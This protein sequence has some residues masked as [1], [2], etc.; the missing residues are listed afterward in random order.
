MKITK[1]ISVFEKLL[2]AYKIA[3]KKNVDHDTLINLHL[4]QGLCF[5]ADNIFNADL[6]G[7]MDYE[8]GYYKN[9]I[10]VKGR[11]FFSSYPM[12][13]F[14]KPTKGK[15]LKTRIDFMESEIKS[16]KRLQ[17]IGFTHV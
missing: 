5:A 1:L 13:L 6:I 11:G 10:K 4:H 7:V 8:Y 12:Y 2:P 9:Y 3:Y 17:K 15:D 14:P 16:L